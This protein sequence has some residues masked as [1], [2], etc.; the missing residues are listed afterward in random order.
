MC[1]CDNPERSGR[2]RV[3]YNSRLLRRFRAYISYE[4]ARGIQLRLRRASVA[5][6]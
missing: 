3:R 2:S 4:A 6:E 5:I 1:D